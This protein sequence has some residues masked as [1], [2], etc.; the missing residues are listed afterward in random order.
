MYLTF[1]DLEESKEIGKDFVYCQIQVSEI[2][3]E[4]IKRAL[5]QIDKECFP[6]EVTDEDIFNQD[7]ECTLESLGFDINID[8]RKRTLSTYE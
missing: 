4:F 2:T 3:T 6:D 8:F 7:V 1:I 5:C